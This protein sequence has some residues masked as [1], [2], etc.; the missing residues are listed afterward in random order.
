MLDIAIY[1]QKGTLV[2]RTRQYQAAIN[3]DPLAP[4]AYVVKIQ[5]ATTAWASK[6]VVE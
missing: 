5:T 2:Y 4:G 6:L 1:D 3:P